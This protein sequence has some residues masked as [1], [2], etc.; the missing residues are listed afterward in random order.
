MG[1]GSYQV[2]ENGPRSRH[3][4][5]RCRFTNKKSC[6]LSSLFFRFSRASHTVAHPFLSHAVSELCMGELS[7]NARRAR[8]T[9][10]HP[11]CKRSRA[12][13]AVL[14]R[15]LSPSCRRLPFC[16]A[17]CGVT[18]VFCSTQHVRPSSRRGC[19]YA[20]RGSSHGPA[21]QYITREARAP[22][23]VC[24]AGFRPH[25]GT[26]LFAP[27]AV[28]VFVFRPTQALLATRHSFSLRVNVLGRAAP[29]Q[30]RATQ[31]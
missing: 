22:L 6:Y 15:R 19:W 5:C 23:T 10:P 26:C 12:P 29:R 20:G 31:S 2:K 13:L 24:A 30:S 7:C 1:R 16:A 14:R 18:V 4:H 8:A 27:Q 28:S 9:A 3:P 21:P 11:D 25:A 17:G